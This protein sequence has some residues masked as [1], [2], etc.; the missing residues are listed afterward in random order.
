MSTDHSASE[1]NLEGQVVHGTIEDIENSQANDTLS[2]RSKVEEWL[3]FSQD[4]KLRPDSAYVLTEP[5]PKK[6]IKKLN[7][8]KFLRVK[9]VKCDEI[10]ESRYSVQWIFKRYEIL[11]S[12]RFYTRR[13]SIVFDNWFL[14]LTI[15]LHLGMT[16]AILVVHR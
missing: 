7:K 16:Q 3:N 6:L 12:F 5:L 13:F 9:E 11:M 4:P 2:S 15:G 10:T 14:P 8:H 1:T